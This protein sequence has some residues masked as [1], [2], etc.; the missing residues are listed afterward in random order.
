MLGYYSRKKQEGQLFF[1]FFGVKTERNTLF[2]FFHWRKGAWISQCV[3]LW[4]AWQPGCVH[5]INDRLSYESTAPSCPPHLWGGAPQGV[6]GGIKRLPQ[7][8]IIDF[9]HIVLMCDCHRQSISWFASLPSQARGPR[10]LTNYLYKRSLI[11]QTKKQRPREIRRRWCPRVNSL[12]L[13]RAISHI[14]PQLPFLSFYLRCPSSY[15]FSF[16]LFLSQF[17]CVLGSTRRS[18]ENLK[19]IMRASLYFLFFLLFSSYVNT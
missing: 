7:S 17:L 10:L 15:F 12:I 5:N 9:C 18:L 3:S 1:S 6:G 19:E 13:K 4:T 8:K 11:S 16:L 2:S 14:L